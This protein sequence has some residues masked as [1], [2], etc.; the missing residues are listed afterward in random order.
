MTV[1]TRSG[2]GAAVA[3]VLL[4]VAGWWWH[5]SELIVIAAV[6]AVLLVGAVWSARHP[7]AL[8]V[9]RRVHTVRVARGDPLVAGHRRRSLRRPRRPDPDSA[10]RGP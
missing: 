5:Y 7:T 9:H 8:V 1:L 3:A 2:L 6:V 4:A 10:R